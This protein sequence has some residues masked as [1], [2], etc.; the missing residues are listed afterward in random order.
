MIPFLQT[1]ASL[2]LARFPFY[3]LGKWSLD[4]SM[5]KGWMKLRV[6]CLIMKAQL[7]DIFILS[8]TKYAIS[9]YT[10]TKYAIFFQKTFRYSNPFLS[11]VTLWK[12]NLMK[13][14]L[15]L[16]QNIQVLLLNVLASIKKIRNS[17]IL[18]ELFHYESLTSCH[19]NFSLTNYASCFLKSD[20]FSRKMGKYTK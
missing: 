15:F 8:L 16:S 9:K 6:Y 5:L 12:L 11:V 7:L 1:D 4:C 13:S 2:K 18:Y 19:L 3:A 20:I 10:I 14:L 17:V